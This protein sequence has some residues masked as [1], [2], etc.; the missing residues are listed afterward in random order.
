MPRDLFSTVV[1]ATPDASSPPVAVPFAQPAPAAPQAELPP[2][3]DALAGALPDWDL[4]PGSP[5]V[6]RVK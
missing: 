3:R 4:L 2:D 6:R 1:P 5:F